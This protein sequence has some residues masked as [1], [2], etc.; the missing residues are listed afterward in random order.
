P[1]TAPSSGGTLGLRVFFSALPMFQPTHRS[2]ERWDGR[3]EVRPRAAL[4]V[5]THPPL[6]RAVGRGDRARSSTPCS[7]FNPPTAPS[8]GGTEDLRPLPQVL[9]EVS[10]HP[11]LLRAVGRRRG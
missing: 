4:H 7:R 6:L 11:P 9:R 2:F 3:D 10:T 8:S 5:S 1:P